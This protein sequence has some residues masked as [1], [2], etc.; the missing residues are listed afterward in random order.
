L[1]KI[2]KLANELKNFLKN[3]PTAYHAT[4]NIIEELEN[5]NFKKLKESNR[6]NIKK[7]GK[8]YIQRNQSA[9][10]AFT[11]GS[12]KFNN[13]FNL[14]GAHTDSPLLKLKGESITEDKSYIK[15]G[16]EVYGGPIINT[17]LDRDLS[18]AGR[19]S[20]KKNGE[21][22][23][24]LID[25]KK[26][27]AVIPNLAIHMNR[28]VNKGFE[29]NKQK[30]LPAIITAEKND[31]VKYT[32]HNLIANQLDIN[33]N[34]IIESDLFLYDST[35]PSITG[36]NDD[37]ISSGRL[38]DLAM[39]HSILKSLTH[40]NNFN[41][42]NIGIFYDNEE[43]GSRTFQGANSN[44]L[45]DLLER[46]TIALGGD[47][48]DYFRALSNSFLISADQA[49]AL[50]PNFKE[51]HDKHYTPIINNGPVIKYNA[52]F[53]Y[54]TTS[55]T[56]SK[57]IN[58]CEKNDIP[59]QKLANR[60]DIKS[61]STIGPM[62]SSLLNVKTVDVGNPLWAMHSIRETAGTKDHFYITEIFK[63]FFK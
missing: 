5:N 39:C 31:D 49:H 63:S 30:H 56:A 29:F 17:W 54:A 53:R 40:K 25:L 21:I 59:Y 50:H 42:T 8:Y 22:V 26:P 51:K 48:E 24:E 33:K 57:F 1:K 10:I 62:S 61:G 52:N 36:L 41:E 3:S 27:L 18:I 38:D 55:E 37:F 45:R 6:W 32:L 28:K 20:I 35:S 16:T 2:N 19:V 43:I 7:D 4:K 23:S 15:I 60:S 47:R 14:I 11:I 34:D 9:V 44:F 12:K 13:G 58:I 46:I